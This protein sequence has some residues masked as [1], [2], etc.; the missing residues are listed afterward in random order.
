LTTLLLD[1]SG[2][3]PIQG[4]YYPSGIFKSPKS[5]DIIFISAKIELILGVA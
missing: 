1:L 3:F 4:I 2:H 5:I